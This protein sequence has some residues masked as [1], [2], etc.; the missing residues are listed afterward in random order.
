MSFHEINFG[1]VSSDRQTMRRTLITIM[2]NEEPGKGK[3]DQCSRY[4]I[5]LEIFKSMG[6]F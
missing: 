5:T 2:L 6:S 4:Q 3:G 1:L